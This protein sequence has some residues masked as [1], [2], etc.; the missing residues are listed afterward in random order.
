MERWS[1]AWVICI[2]KESRLHICGTSII[3][4]QTNMSVVSQYPSII[5][6][7]YSTGATI[8]PQASDIV[9]NT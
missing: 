9:S 4:K 3:F 6:I 5:S 8:S 2:S 7:C 1:F